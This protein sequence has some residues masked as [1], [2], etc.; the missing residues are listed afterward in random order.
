MNEQGTAWVHT[1]QAENYITVHMVSFIMSVTYLCGN[2]T[3]VRTVSSLHQRP[4]KILILVA[5]WLYTASFITSIPLLMSY[6]S[7]RTLLAQL[8]RYWS[9]EAI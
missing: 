1:V 8:A 5:I 9:P 2:Y 4:T 3:V 6:A 7:E